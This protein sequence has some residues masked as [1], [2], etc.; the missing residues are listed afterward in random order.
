M[1]GVVR[2]S[3][4]LRKNA[5]ILLTSE[6]EV[7]CKPPVKELMGTP[8]RLPPNDLILARK[9]LHTPRHIHSIAAVT[10]LRPVST[11]TTYAAQ[12]VMRCIAARSV[13]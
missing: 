9:W 4:D 10:T 13:P 6:E 2:S 1:L 8:N 12:D 11:H 5:T 3:T 7:A